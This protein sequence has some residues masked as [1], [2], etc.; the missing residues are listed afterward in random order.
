[1][2]PSRLKA[3]VGCG[4][5]M[6][7]SGARSDFHHSSSTAPKRP[8]PRAAPTPIRFARV[9]IAGRSIVLH[10]YASRSYTQRLQSGRVLAQ[11]PLPF[12]RVS[13]AGRSIVASSR[14][15]DTCVKKLRRR[16]R[17][18]HGRLLQ[19]RGA[20]GA[21]DARQPEDE[22]EHRDKTAADDA[23]NHWADIRSSGR[24]RGGG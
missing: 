4:A 19:R 1:M 3:A 20:L 16:H 6:S 12:A 18:D 7:R 15:Q 23:A 5:A 14:P 13:I 22:H 9:S 24:R 2:E 17:S 10:A 21:E 11:L 8:S